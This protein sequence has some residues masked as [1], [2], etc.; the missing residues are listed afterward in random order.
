MMSVPTLAAA[1]IDND[2]DIRPFRDLVL[3][4]RLSGPESA[5][6]GS[7]AA[8]GD[9]EHSVND[10]LSRDQGDRRRKTVVGRPGHA[11]RPALCHGQLFFRTVRQFQRDQRFIDGVFPVGDNIDDRP[12]YI[13]RDHAFV[14]D[15]VGLRHFG[16]D[17]PAVEILAFLNCEMGLPFFLPV[18]GVHADAPCDKRAAGGF[19]DPLQGTLDA[20]EDIIEDARSEGDGNGI[21]ACHDFFPGAQAGR[22]LIHL[23][24]GHILVQGDDLADQLLGS[25]IDHL[26]HAESGIAF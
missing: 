12:F 13:R 22:L 9:G 20:V 2:V 10:T 16:D 21:S 25:H 23:D 8:L 24:R 15:G 18:Q 3:C 7:S 1:D 19:R 5:G 4:H 6:D 17:I 26:G 11:D 14:H